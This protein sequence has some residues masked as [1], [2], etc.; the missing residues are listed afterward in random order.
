MDVTLT[1]MNHK[2]SDEY[3]QEIWDSAKK[4]KILLGH[5]SVMV[6]WADL[7]HNYKLRH[8]LARAVGRQAKGIQIDCHHKLCFSSC[9][10]VCSF[11]Q[12]LL[13][14]HFWALLPERGD[15]PLFLRFRH[16]WTSD[17]SCL[18]H[19]FTSSFFLTSFHHQSVTETIASSSLLPPPDLTQTC[20][21]SEESSQ[22]ILLFSLF[23]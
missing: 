14:R 3:V 5:V 22:S 9:G 11:R 8:G 19:F 17:I 10:S 18:T 15:S 21:P 6:A 23:C 12:W 20:L 16:R 13:T 2:Y 4:K 7:W 1:P